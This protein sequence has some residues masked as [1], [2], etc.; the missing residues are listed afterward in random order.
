[1][2]D[3]QIE[4]RID[5]LNDRLIM[6]K[7]LL[8][9]TKHQK[10]RKP[11]DYKGKR[12]GLVFLFTF[13]KNISAMWNASSLVPRFEFGLPYPFLT[14]SASTPRCMKVFTCHLALVCPIVEV[15]WRTFVLTSPVM[16]YMSC[17]YWMVYEMGGMWPRSCCFVGCCFLE[18]IQNSM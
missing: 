1:M 8:M 17:L 6:R 4:R 15:H 14:R 11:R 16:L 18:F 5:L 12:L 7:D 10:R 3:T 2:N 9:T 13:P